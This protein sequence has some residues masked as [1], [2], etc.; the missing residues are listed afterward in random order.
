MQISDLVVSGW[1]L[2]EERRGEGGSRVKNITRV[3]KKIVKSCHFFGGK[4]M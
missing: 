3:Q 4:I 2:G 1:G